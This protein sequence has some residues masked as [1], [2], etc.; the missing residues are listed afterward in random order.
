[1]FYQN[2]CFCKR[3]HNLILPGKHGQRPCSVNFDKPRYFSTK[4]AKDNHTKQP[5]NLVWDI[6][7]YLM[8]SVE[9]HIILVDW[10][11]IWW[12][13]FSCISTIKYEEIWRSLLKSIFQKNQKYFS[14]QCG[15]WVRWFPRKRYYSLTGRSFSSLYKFE[16]FTHLLELKA[17]SSLGSPQI[18]KGGNLPERIW[19][20]QKHLNHGLA[21]S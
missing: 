1:M 20:S 12:W 21:S 14:C 3:R 4:S 7:I 19:K 16:L 8:L 11:M 6:Y 9:Q 17:W 5:S 18:V 2:S 15:H 10:E 13:L